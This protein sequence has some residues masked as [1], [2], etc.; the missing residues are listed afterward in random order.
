MLTP[1]LWWVMQRREVYKAVVVTTQHLHLLHELFPVPEAQQ[2]HLQEVVG[3]QQ[4]QVPSRDVVVLEQE[5]VLC[6]LAPAKT[7]QPLNHLLFRPLL[8]IVRLPGST[9]LAWKP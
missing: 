2:S 4:E 6:Q 8:H 3:S 1:D 7:Q 9:L 5:G